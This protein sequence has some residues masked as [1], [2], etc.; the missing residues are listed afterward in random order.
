[1]SDHRCTRLLK[2]AAQLCLPLQKFLKFN[3]IYSNEDEVI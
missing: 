2:G 1:M 3:N